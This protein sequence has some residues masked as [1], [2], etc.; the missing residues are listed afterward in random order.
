MEQNPPLKSETSSTTALVTPGLIVLAAGSDEASSEVVATRE[1]PPAGCGDD[2]QE[3]FIRI[4]LEPICNSL[5]IKLSKCLCFQLSHI[6]PNLFVRPSTETANING[7]ADTAATSE[8]SVF[9]DTRFHAMVERIY[10]F[11]SIAHTLTGM[12]TS[13]ALHV[14]SIMQKLIY[15]ER[16]ATGNKARVITNDSCFGIFLL[17]AIILSIK[18]NRDK[19]LPNKTW[20]DVF[21]LPLVDL[22][23]VEIL[24]LHR[25]DFS[26]TMSSEVYS[27][28]YRM[29]CL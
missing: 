25:L 5:I 27:T 10:G 11:F 29:F 6:T 4:S 16:N 13:E 28:L 24:V 22:N 2:A 26:L 17:I 23:R 7:I 9:S 21:K 8:G 15:V 20:S 3:T 18:H 14:M 1:T 19:P 12:T